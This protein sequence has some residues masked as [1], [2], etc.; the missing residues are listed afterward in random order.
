M[1]PLREHRDDIAQLV[2]YFL[3]RICKRDARR[4]IRLEPSAG[5][6]LRDYHWPGNVRELENVCERAAVMAGGDIVRSNL[7]H[8]WLQD[9]PGNAD[10]LSNLRPGYILQDME[11]QMIERTLM[12]FNGHREK[13]AKALGIGV[14]TLGMK[15][16]KWHDESRR[17]G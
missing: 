4:A 15:L 5:R 12:Q 2:E 1:P 13:T 16:K 11:R 3:E 14:R 7:L 17:V 8:T 10:V 9:G 6:L